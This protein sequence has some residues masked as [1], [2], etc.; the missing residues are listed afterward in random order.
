MK[1]DE[2]SA[3]FKNLII[4]SD[5]KTEIKIYKNFISIFTDLN[6][7]D[8]SE[9]QLKSIEEKLDSL[10]FNEN[11]DNRKKHF[12]QKLN[13]FV[14]YLKEKLSLISKGYYTAIGM[15]L[16][17]SFGVA[18]GAAFKNVSY[19]LIFG[20]LIG[21]LIGIAKDSKAKKEGKVLS[22]NL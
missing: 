4:E 9:E 11:S 21:M 3:F 1:L 16:G 17:M 10:N 15:S 19:G 14:G 7:R 18:F 8:L 12:K 5:N 20:M 2:A 6:N 22:T 13:L